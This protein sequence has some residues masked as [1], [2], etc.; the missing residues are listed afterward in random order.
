V[1]FT[2]IRT[3]KK[4]KRKLS[5]ETA[6]KIKPKSLRVKTIGKGTFAPGMIRNAVFI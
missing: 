4:E 2:S 1:F 6:P 3:G 5:T